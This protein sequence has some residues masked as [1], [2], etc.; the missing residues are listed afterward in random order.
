M[1]GSIIDTLNNEGMW[2]NTA[3][4]I[5]SDHGGETTS[6]GDDTY[7]ERTIP[8]IVKTPQ[9]AGYEIKREVRI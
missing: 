6:Y 5:S 7:L 9:S 4:L 1:V 8:F 3:L 2:N